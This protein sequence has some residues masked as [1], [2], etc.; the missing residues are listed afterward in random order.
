MPVLKLPMRISGDE[1][2]LFPLCSRTQGA[3]TVSRCSQQHQ[4]H[5]FGVF[6]PHFGWFGLLGA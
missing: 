4:K 5:D 1:L 3:P 6:F 2:S